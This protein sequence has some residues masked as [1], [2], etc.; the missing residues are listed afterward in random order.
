M[1]LTRELHGQNLLKLFPDS[2]VKNPTALVST[3][4]RIDRKGQRISLAAC[5]GEIAE[6]KF[7]ELTDNLRIKAQKILGTKRVYD[8]TDPRGYFLKV[9]LRE[10][11][12]LFRD[13]GGCGIIAPRF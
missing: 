4:I 5:N 9:T 2:T 7:I 11:E 12:S 1:K 6:D 8:E 10:N 13:F 3:L